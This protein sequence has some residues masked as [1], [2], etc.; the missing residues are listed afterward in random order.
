MYVNE[1][2]YFSNSQSSHSDL[3]Q[4]T[5]SNSGVSLLQDSFTSQDDIYFQVASDLESD[6]EVHTKKT[7]R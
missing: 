6:L 2:L 5:P 1:D 7:Y 4:C 3:S